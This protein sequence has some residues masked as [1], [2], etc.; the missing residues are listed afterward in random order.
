MKPTKDKYLSLN[1]LTNALQI[2]PGAIELYASK[3]LISVNPGLPDSKVFSPLDQVRIR[4]II[5]AKNADYSLGNI[6]K[7]IGD[8]DPIKTFTD[9]IDECMIYGKKVYSQLE[10]SLNGMDMLEQI[11]VTCDMELL[12]SY[13]KDLNN[14]KYGLHIIPPNDHPVDPGKIEIPE[15]SMAAPAHVLSTPKGAK[16]IEAPKKER[17]IRF[18]KLLYAGAII[19]ILIMFA[20]NYLNDEPAMVAEQKDE[21]SLIASNSSNDDLNDLSTSNLGLD[22]SA[23]ERSTDIEEVSPSFNT[24]EPED[25]DSSIITSDL[26][27]KE[28]VITTQQDNSGETLDINM[29]KNLDDLDSAYTSSEAE[30]ASKLEDELF[31]KLVSDLTAKYDRQATT[32]LPR[33][34]DSKVPAP[35]NAQSSNKASSDKTISKAKSPKNSSTS[36]KKE[37]KT[38]DST[39][40]F[41]MF[42]GTT[43][44]VKKEEPKAPTPKTSLKKISKGKPTDV[45][46]KKPKQVD[47]K[48]T[49]ASK[50]AEK[51]VKIPTVTIQ[52]KISPTTDSETLARKSTA[53][54]IKIESTVS[55][56]DET[57]STVTTLPDANQTSPPRPTNPE[58]LK[59]VQ[60]S[61]ESVVSGNVSEAII[62]ASVAITLDP[63]AINAYIN[64]SWAYSKKGLFD[65]AIQDCNKALELDPKNA[66]AYNNRGLAFQGGGD[67]DKAKSDY[68]QACQL[69]FEVGCKNYNEVAGILATKP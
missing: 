60:K 22:D 30:S 57:P 13:L 24:L 18:Q 28:T 7:L 62:S 5:N 9:Q 40:E 29:S 6:R 59:W 61:Y 51:V 27:E 8:L 48:P 10:E 25:N 54:T 64:R 56:D 45:A 69:G 49:I 43:A 50:P 68:Q 11:N 20:Y 2:N 52:E 36:S 17:K 21:F 42:A 31:K 32:K 66:L 39:R 47:Q 41:S 16:K 58:A 3:K 65:K 67:L 4:F 12:S 34:N 46:P 63:A 26:D 15:Q 53:S 19:L 38:D 33:Q 55:K 37:N 23:D 14:L 44:I 1:E 35:L